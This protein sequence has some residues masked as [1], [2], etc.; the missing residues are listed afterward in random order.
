M[1]MGVSDWWILERGTFPREL[2]SWR[3]DSTR[4]EECFM[5]TYQHL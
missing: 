5:V 2:A 3:L 1:A 4:F